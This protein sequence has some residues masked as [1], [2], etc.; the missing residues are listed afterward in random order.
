MP[1]SLAFR[2]MGY[3]AKVSTSLPECLDTAFP[4]SSRRQGSAEETREV[5]PTLEGK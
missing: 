2:K 5:L 4:M 3:L 1:K